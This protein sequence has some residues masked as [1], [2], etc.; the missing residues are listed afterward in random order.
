VKAFPSAAEHIIAVGH[1]SAGT[2]ALALA[3][4]DRR[5]E[6]CIA[7]APVT[8]VLA[9]LGPEN[10]R[11]LA[12]KTGAREVLSRNSPAEFAPKLK[13]PTFLFVAKDDTNVSAASIEAYATRLRLT[14][15][16]VT[17]KGVE[18]GGHYEAMIEPG[19]GLALAW[20]RGK[21]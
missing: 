10:V 7:F 3:A 11:A 21:R 18:S 19:Q 12:V 6:K 8:D 5:I 20:L 14:G 9:H 2:L 1:S 15:C 17:F 4:H 13:K 16:P